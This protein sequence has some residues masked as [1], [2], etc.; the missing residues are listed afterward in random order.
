MMKKQKN[1]F[2]KLRLNWKLNKIKIL[3]DIL[4]IIEI[5]L[6]YLIAWFNSRLLE[7]SIIIPLFFIYRSKYEK[8]W[9]AETLFKCACY[10]VVL[11][12][13]ITLFIPS[14]NI[15]IFCSVFM[16]YIITKISYYVKDYN[17]KNK[18]L[19]KKLESMTFD[20]MKA[21]FTTYTEYE[22][23]A[24]YSY[25]NRGDKLADNI[26]MKYNYSTRQL[27]RIIKKMKDELK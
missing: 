21:R 20:E 26:A 22:L 17:D 23:N 15:S 9:H 7:V 1:F 12:F 3:Y 5:A 24:V 10:S 11:F 14:K 27:Q 18:L 19:T 2:L 16:P 4:G 8:Q 13:F 6:I 25:I